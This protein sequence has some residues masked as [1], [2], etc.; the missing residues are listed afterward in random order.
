MSDLE[1]R[2]LELTLRA[3]SVAMEHRVLST[4]QAPLLS[5]EVGCDIKSGD[6]EHGA[7]VRDTESVS[8]FRVTQSELTTGPQPAESRPVI[9]RGLAATVVWLV[10]AASLLLG[11]AI[12]RGLPTSTR[13]AN[14]PVGAIDQS[15]PAAK[16]TD[17]IRRLADEQVNASKALESDASLTEIS[18]SFAVSTGETLPGSGDASQIAESD[19]RSPRE[20]VAAWELRTGQIFNVA[21]HIRDL[22]FN[23]CR[24]CHRIGG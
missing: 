6:V 10:A 4:L 8:A 1:S 14:L 11:V 19:S 24:E 12:G 13:H 17:E 16:G 5:G 18:E 21:T 9:R 20:A 22:R 15:R 2:I 3:P 23:V 7:A